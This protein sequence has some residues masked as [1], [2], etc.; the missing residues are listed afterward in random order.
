MTIRPGSDRSLYAVFGEEI[1]VEMHRKVARAVRA[2]QGIAGIVNL[3]PG[4]TSVLVDFDPRLLTHGQANNIILE[5]LERHQDDAP[6]IP[7]E[8]EI[9]VAYGGEAGPDL[10]DVARHT[11]LSPER[12]IELH[13]SAE[14]F[15]YFVGF[16]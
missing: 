6:P 5:A 3:H 15:V 10:E 4:Y 16:S 13:S 8:I 1:S 2:L 11:G 7:R 14:Y 12:V 9:P